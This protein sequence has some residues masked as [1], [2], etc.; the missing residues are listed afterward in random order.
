MTP[1]GLIEGFERGHADLAR[2]CADLEKV[3]DGLPNNAERSACASIA[4]R[5][6]ELVGEVCRDEEDRLFP[7]LLRRFPELPDLPA[8]FERLKA[9]HHTD[10]CYAEEIEEALAAF[11]DGRPTLSTDAI[12]YMLRGFFDG[13][14]RHIAAERQFLLPLLA[15]LGDA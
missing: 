5:V 11:G 14:R 13:Q 4:H 12:G 6:P 9:E 10:L 7:F 8:A 2:L 1:R 3:A 15:R